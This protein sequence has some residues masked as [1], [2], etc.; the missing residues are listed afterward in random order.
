[1][2]RGQVC[3]RTSILNTNLHTLQVVQIQVHSLDLK[4][5]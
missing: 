5:Q 3:M 4:T 2:K 1:M